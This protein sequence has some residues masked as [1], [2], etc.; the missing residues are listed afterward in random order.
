MFSI[1][2]TYGICQ[3]TVEAIKTMYVDHSALVITPDCETEEFSISSGV[4]QGDP[5][6]PLLFIIVLDWQ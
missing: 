6:D 3:H 5:L 2:H 4:L 1:L